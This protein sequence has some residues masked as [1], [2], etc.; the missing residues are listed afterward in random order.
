ME[1]K[2]KIEK[3]KS[4]F[5]K[6]V[7]IFII[8]FIKNLYEFTVR[9]YNSD[10]VRSPKNLVL[11]RKNSTYLKSFWLSIIKLIKKGTKNENGSTEDFI[12][13]LN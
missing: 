1:N 7:K 10:T 13:G 4:F 12:K 8:I 5:N 11:T 2:L 9:Y 6:D 3:K